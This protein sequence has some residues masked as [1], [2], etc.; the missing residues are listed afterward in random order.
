[1][2]EQAYP[3]PT[4]F[5][6]DANTVFA[7]DANTEEALGADAA[8]EIEQPRSGKRQKS[9]IQFPYNDLASTEELAAALHNA[10]GGQCDVPQLAASL[11]QQPTSG[12]FRLKLSAA[13]M[14]GLIQL[15]AG[16][17]TIQRLGMAILN[18][19]QRDAARVQ[20]FMNVPL[21]E[22]LFREYRLGTLP[23]DQGVE[24]KMV[25]LGVT[26]SQ[27]SRARQIFARAAEQAGFFAAGRNRLVEPT[28]G[29]LEAA[30][31]SAI[32]EPA[33]KQ[34]EAKSQEDE[35]SVLSDPMLTGLFKRFLPEEGAPFP[36]H[37]RQ[38]L[39]R[40][41]AITLDAIYGEPT[42]GEMDIT[43]FGRLFT[44]G[45]ADGSRGES[46]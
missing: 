28:T 20:A 44:S 22:R 27:A 13:A 17:I 2:T 41:F 32:L 24:A 37:D 5:A 7:E 10:R 14:Y 34:D 29:T 30:G 35:V 19:E 4:V 6:E 9:T 11:N 31:G 33:R 38:R 46:I 45:G 42:D 23:N 39:L 18:P 1:M 25:N 26:P 3:D 40:S 15:E 36:A 16:T 21:Y 12:A 8:P 43:A